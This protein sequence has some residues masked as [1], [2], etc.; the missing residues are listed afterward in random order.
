[1][2]VHTLRRIR[3]FRFVL[4]LGD[5]SAVDPISLGA[6]AA[7]CGL[8]DEH[9]VAVFVDNSPTVIAEQLAA[10]GVPQ[11]RFRGGGDQSSP[12]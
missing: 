9:R 10:A 11:Q 3:P 12:S 2:L 1:L 4:D 8:G 5:V 7:T 6:L